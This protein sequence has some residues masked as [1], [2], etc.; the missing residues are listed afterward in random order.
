M[1]ITKKGIQPAGIHIDRE[2]IGLSS[3]SAVLL[4]GGQFLS[5]EKVAGVIVSQSL[6]KR[7]R[8]KSFT[9]MNGA[10]LGMN[11]FLTTN[12]I[13]PFDKAGE[14]LTLDLSPIVRLSSI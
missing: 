11:A 7:R 4:Q 10:P 3:V 6:R 14:A 2:K 8:E 5:C 12:Q 1:C 13:E 9:G